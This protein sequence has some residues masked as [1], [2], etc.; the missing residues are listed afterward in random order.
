[1]RCI[2]KIDKDYAVVDH[3]KKFVILFDRQFKII[4]EI[5]LS[6]FKGNYEKPNFCGICYDKK[7]KLIYVVNSGSDQIS[8]V[9][10]K[11]KKV[12]DKI[13]FS[14][15]AQSNSYHHINDMS[16]F[17]DKLLVSYFSLS[18]NWKNGIFDGGVTEID[19]QSNK[20]REILDKLWMPH[21]VKVLNNNISVLNSM[22]GELIVG[23]E[24]SGIFPGFAR[25]L[26]CDENYYYIGQS[27]TMYMSRLF[28]HSKNIMCNGGIYIFDKSTRASRFL[29][30]PDIMNV[31]D[32]TGLD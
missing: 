2:V 24:I 25:G 22:K 11:T 3:F 5:D 20:K 23:N 10:I 9:D 17:N 15:H 18:G 1:M 31:H 7:N 28:G 26:H 27:E 4:E 12:L 13:S 16:F 14:H 21:S 8:I 29:S 6:K 19:P 30:C 32:I